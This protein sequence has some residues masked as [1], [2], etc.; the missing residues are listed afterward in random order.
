MSKKQPTIE[1]VKNVLNVGHFNSKREVRDLDPIEPT[2]MRLPI[3]KIDKY[4]RN[5]RKSKNPEYN[6]ILESLRANGQ[7][8]ALTVTRRPGSENY[9]IRRGGNTRLDIMN[10]LYDEAG[11]SRFEFIDCLFMPWTS[12]SD[13]IVGHL[14]ENTTQGRMTLI[15]KARGYRDFKIEYEAEHSVELG[16]RKL[17]EL[18]KEKGASINHKLLGVMYYALDVLDPAIPETLSRGLGKPQVEKLKRLDQTF[19]RLAEAH[20]LYETSNREA[21]IR[22]EFHNLLAEHDGDEW[23]MDLVIHEFTQRIGGLLDSVSFSRLKYDIDQCLK[24]DP[25]KV[26]LISTLSDEEPTTTT[27]ANPP[28]PTQKQPEQDQHK[29]EPVTQQ[30]TL[31]ERMNPHREDIT[32]QSSPGAAS[33][34]PDPVIPKMESQFEEEEEFDSDDEASNEP[35][36]QRQTPQSHMGYSPTGNSLDMVHEPTL[37]PPQQMFTAGQ[38]DLKSMRARIYTLALQF[39]KTTAVHSSVVPWNYGYGYFMDLPKSK[40]AEC[41]AAEQYY[42]DPEYRVVVNRFIKERDKA[43]KTYAWWLLWQA[44]GLLDFRH[45]QPVPGYHKMPECMMKTLINQMYNPDDTNIYKLAFT[46][47]GHIFL[48]TGGPQHIVDMAMAYSYVTPQNMIKYVRLL[49]ARTQ[50]MAYVEEHRINLWEERS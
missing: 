11:D 23:D 22:A 15:D 16:Q 34:K 19:Q 50:L 9:M 35:I 6:S 13:C 37:D 36:I 30:T 41:M 4:D 18:L 39:A 45:H 32:K 21:Q 48:N 33:I 2:A 43:Q 27:V 46:A 24:S 1:T 10:M 20:Q 28:T 3:K 12:E 31:T 14:N 26:E 40:L 17:A 7:E 29:Q 5:P 47:M 42:K 44:Q 49:E 25:W 8:E 38:L